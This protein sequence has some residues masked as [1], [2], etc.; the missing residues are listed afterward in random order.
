MA[1]QLLIQ[2]IDYIIVSKTKTKTMT[3]TEKGKTRWPWQVNFILPSVTKKETKV[4][5]MKKQRQ[6]KMQQTGRR[7]Y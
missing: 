4:E 6:D 5:T 2:D 1:G 3:M 7:V